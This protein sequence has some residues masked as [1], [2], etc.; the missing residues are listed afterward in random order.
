MPTQ[1]IAQAQSAATVTLEQEQL[2]NFLGPVNGALG[3]LSVAERTSKYF[4]VYEGA[5]GTG[6]EIIDQTAIFITYLVDDSGNV[7]KPSTE[8]IS[9]NNLIQNFEIGTNVIVRNDVAT[10]T[11]N[12][13]AGKHKITG[14]GRQ[15]PLL[16]S[17]TGS[18]AGANVTELNFTSEIDQP[19]PSMY[20]NMIKPAFSP[21]SGWD[22]TWTTLVNYNSPTITPDPTAANYNNTAGTYSIV[23]SGITDISSIKFKVLG[24]FQNSLNYSTDISLRIRREGS[25]LA[26]K[27]YTIPALTNPQDPQDGEQGNGFLNT[28]NDPFEFTLGLPAYFT[29]DPEF[30]VQM[31][32]DGGATYIDVNFIKFQVSAQSPQAGF[33]QASLPF[34][35]N[36][37]GTNLWLT[38]SAEISQNYGNIQNSQNVLDEIEPGFNFSPVTTPLIPKPGDRI[39]FEYNIDTE[40]TIYEVIPPD[41]DSDGLLKIRLNTLISNTVN[42]NNFV[43]HRVDSNDPVYIIIDVPKNQLVSSNELFKGILLPEYPTKKLKDNIDSLVLDLKEKGIIPNGN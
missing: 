4:V 42:K 10:A 23:T 3:G 18:T 32:I 37:S 39:R 6:P 36:N 33:P 38:A 17:Q 13:I 2:N 26:T 34:W 15:L 24:E 19:V 8:Y 28:S 30:D 29:G 1:A 25:V 11:N 16:Y 5:G 43:L 7:S 40:Y 27:T 22:N 35:S 21:T 9:L 20:G 41:E 12:Q 14:I 31:S